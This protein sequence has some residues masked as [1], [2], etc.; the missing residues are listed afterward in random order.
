[1][2]ELRNHLYGDTLATTFNDLRE[3]IAFAERVN[4]ARHLGQGFYQVVKR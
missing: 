3:A 2:Y 1:M 4:T